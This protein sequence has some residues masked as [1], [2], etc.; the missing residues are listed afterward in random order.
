MDADSEFDEASENGLGEV[1]LESST[2]SF[3][4]KRLSQSRDSAE[5]PLLSRVLSASSYGR[6]RRPGSRLNQKVYIASEDLTAVFAG[7]STSMGGFAIYMV[8]CIVTGGL[9]YLLFRWLPRWRVKLTGKASPL[10]KCQWIAIEVSKARALSIPVKS[11]PFLTPGRTN[12]ISFPF[13]IL[14]A[15]P[16]GG[17]FP[18][19]LWSLWVTSTTRIA[20]QQSHRCDLSTTDTYAFAITQLRINSVQSAAGRTLHG[21]MPESCERV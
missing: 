21:L 13:R 16:T 18:R 15:S 20:T 17:H 10:A 12:G 3:I 9:A 7:F 11:R 4:S 1:D 14:E 2:G 8:M 5:H 19:S 6:D